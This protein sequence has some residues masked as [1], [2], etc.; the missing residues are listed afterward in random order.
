MATAGV[1]THQFDDAAIRGSIK[2][3]FRVTYD[4]TKPLWKD[5]GFEESD[6]IK[7]W[8]EFS[9]FTGIGLAPQRE[10]FQQVAIDV[11][12]QN[13]TQRVNLL[14]YAIAIPVSDTALRFLKRAQVQLKDALKAPKMAA[15]SMSQTNEVL[16]SDVFGNAFST[17]FTGMDGVPLVST[18]HKLGRGGTTSNHLGAVSFA[19]ASLEAAIIQANKFP[20]DVGLPVGVR[21]GERWLVLP[22]E[23]SFEADRIL[24]S[25]QQSNTA[26]NAINTVKG[27][28]VSKPNRYLPSTSN[29]F[30]VNKGEEDGLHAIFETK[31][32]MKEF[33]DDKVHAMFFEAYQMVA[34]TFGL[35]WRRVQGSN[36]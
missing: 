7:P 29:W 18:A 5:L 11:P 1:T 28:F 22:E 20:D 9:S 8:E 13:Y 33:S 16:A 6:T 23:Y 12:K 35:N 31:P 2:S 19:Q 3:A 21:N 30:V 15:E 17:D 26:N 36:V 32:M 10:E 24:N 4:N 34:F 27:K 25:T 14:E